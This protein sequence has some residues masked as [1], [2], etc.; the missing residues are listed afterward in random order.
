MLVRG[1]D[2][3]CCIIFDIFLSHWASKNA[4]RNREDLLSSIVFAHLWYTVLRCTDVT[5]FSLCRWNLC[6]MSVISV[7][8]EILSG[9][10]SCL[11]FYTYL[12]IKH[13]WN[14]FCIVARSYLKHTFIRRNK[15]ITLYYQGLDFNQPGKRTWKSP[16]LGSK[17]CTVVQC[18]GGRER[19]YSPAHYERCRCEIAR[20]YLKSFLVSVSVSILKCTA[21]TVWPVWFGEAAHDKHTYIF[22]RLN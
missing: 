3:I 9:Y 22:I 5:R 10:P 21:C 14:G 4:H 2:I 6:A 13:P 12:N 20:C 11:K 8:H 15:A 1:R 7:C 16:G 18:P 17:I 19:F